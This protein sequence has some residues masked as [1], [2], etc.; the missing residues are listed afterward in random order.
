[1]QAHYFALH[2]TQPFAF[3]ATSDLASACWIYLLIY[4]LPQGTFFIHYEQLLIIVDQFYNLSLTSMFVLHSFSYVM[5][6][7]GCNSG[8]ESGQL[9]LDFNLTLLSLSYTE[10]ISPLRSCAFWCTM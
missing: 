8:Y 1:M 3:N 7:L 5:Q 4:K 6:I 10:V 2:T 9:N